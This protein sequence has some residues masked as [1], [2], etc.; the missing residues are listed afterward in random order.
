[1]VRQGSGRIIN[2][3][4]LTG[5]TPVP[6]RGIYSATKAAVMRLTDA[7][8]VELKAL[9]VQVMLVAPGFIKS[10]ARD[11]AHDV[12]TWYCSKSLWCNWLS[13]LE[14][15]MAKLLVNAVPAEY[16]AETLVAVALRRQMPR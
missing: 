16:Y 14:S 6:L 2:I 12:A 5:F 3:G 4:S 1:M 7:L 9:G 8:R 10:N 15:C 11:T 13:V